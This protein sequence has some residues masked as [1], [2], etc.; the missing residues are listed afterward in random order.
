MGHLAEQLSAIWRGLED[1]KAKGKQLSR[2]LDFDKMRIQSASK[3]EWNGELVTRMRTLVS[4]EAVGVEVGTSIRVL[5]RAD[6]PS[7]LSMVYTV[8]DVTHCATNF[9]SVRH[10]FRAPFRA[11]LKGIIVD[12]QE[13]EVSQTGNPKRVFDLVD[14]QGAYVTCCAMKHNTSSVVLRPQQEVV[15][16]FGTG[17]GPIGSSRGMFYLMKDSIIIPV[18]YPC[19]L[20]AGKTELVD[21][22]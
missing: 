3:N 5:P 20:S 16:H 14:S 17:R 7:M 9:R 2:V 19:L 15:L 11:S 6:V 4:I 8:P 21:I 12:V 13:I 22:Q 18:R 1:D 10:K